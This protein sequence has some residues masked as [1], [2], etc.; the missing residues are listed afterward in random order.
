MKTL[1][2][3]CNFLCHRAIHTM[4]ALSYEDE[5]TG[6]IFGFL[7]Q[8]LSYAKVFKTN[9][10]IFCWD[11]KESKRSKIYPEYKANRINNDAT[12]EEI[13]LKKQGYKQFDTL[14][15]EILPDMGFKNVYMQ[16]GYEADDLIATT[17]EYHERDFTI[18]T[19]DQDMYQ[20][21]DFADMWNPTSKKLYTYDDFV[22]N[23]GILPEKWIVIK[24]L[25]GCSSD[26]IR[27]ISGVGEKTA[28]K[29]LRKELKPTTNT[30]KKIKSKVTDLL[31]VNTQLVK[32]PFKGTNIYKI[33]NNVLDFDKFIQNTCYRYSFDSFLNDKYWLKWENFFTGRF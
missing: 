4:G 18:I 7:M 11:S 9:D 12:D 6:V 26:N 8:L 21:L 15:K 17:V 1:V 33:Q 31:N 14:R 3:D 10:I 27:G 20:L 16:K 2:I 24:S 23:W 29:Y 25:A 5:K 13:E 28:A 19:A 32:L 22:E 30:Y